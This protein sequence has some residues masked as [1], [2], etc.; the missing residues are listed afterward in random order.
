MTD[1]DF[2]TATRDSY[3]A[4]VD[5]YVRE[6]QTALDEAPL[7]RAM[8]GLFAELVLSTGNRTVADVGC[9]PGRVTVLLAGHGLDAVGVDLS[10]GM[11][12]HARQA[13]PQLRFE[14]GSMLELD[15]PDSGLGG[16]L[17][18]FS[19]IH[20]PYDRRPAAFAEFH[21][22]LTPGGYLMLVFQ[23]GDEIRHRDEFEGKRI[24]LSFHRQ[25]P[26]EVARLLAEAGFLV[27]VTV[28]QTPPAPDRPPLGIL[29]ARKA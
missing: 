28:E 15:L 22:V 1:S 5:E 19:I 9:G 11:I 10:P 26:A 21:R 14:V 23:V 24:D 16:L 3:D 2:L 17:A 13:Y 7:D 12:T 29:V 27:L 4:I 18:Y 6:V 25:R 20:L 8:L